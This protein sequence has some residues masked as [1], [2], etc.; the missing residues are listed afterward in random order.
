ML[1]SELILA[2]RDGIDED[3]TADVSDA[4]IL[5]ALNRAQLKLA[6]LAVRKYPPLFSREHTESGVSTQAVAIPETSYA[7]T[8]NEVSVRPAGTQTWMP[9]HRAPAAQLIG[10]DNETTTSTPAYWDQQGADIKLYPTPAN[11]DVRI[12]Y[13]VKPLDL[14]VEQARITSVS[15]QTVYLDAIGADLTTS[16]A[17]LK[18]FVNLVD[19]TTGAVKGTMQVSAVPSSIAS[20]LQFKASSLDRATVFGQTVDTVLATDVEA[21][22][23]VCIANGTCVPNLLSDYSDYLVLAAVV[24]LRRAAGEDTTAEVAQLRELEDDVRAM[25]AGRAAGLRVARKSPYWGTSQSLLQRY[26]G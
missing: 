14:V 24:E 21:D 8:V 20:P 7:F 18:A 19:G 5:R 22:D 1:V 4:K 6:R 23:Y 2:V 3:D 9:C 13:Q 26:R 12:R 16:I 11:T 17:Q 25:W 15:G 10:L